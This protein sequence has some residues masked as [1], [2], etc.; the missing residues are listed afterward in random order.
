MVDLRSALRPREDLAPLPPPVEEIVARANQR[1]SRRRLGVA[2]SVMAVVAVLGGAAVVAGNAR[3]DDP[4]TRTTL[5]SETADSPPPIDTPEDPGATGPTAPTGPTETTATA[6]TTEATT[7]TSDA[8]PSQ[9]A[10]DPPPPPTG[11]GTETTTVI[12]DTQRGTGLGQVA[13]AGAWHPCTSTC[14][15]AADGTYQWTNEAGASVTVRFSGTG[16]AVFGVK[17][18]WGYI[19]TVAIDGGPPV[20][21]DYY[22]AEAT[23]TPVEVFRSG[24]LP[25]G[26]HTLVLTYSGRKNPASTGGSAITF[27]R[28]EVTTTTS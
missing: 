4:G 17:E 10:D 27:D 25:P 24:D 9:P 20:D 6:P 15:K 21:A 3:T 16:I 28:A 23:A 18:P 26:E 7:T 1:Q 12:P 8:P 13:F 2:A 14:D 19:A 11:T 5:G 22:A